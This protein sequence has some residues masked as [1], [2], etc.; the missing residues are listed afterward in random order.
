MAA[1]VIGN[2]AYPD[3][4]GLANPTNDAND[5][6]AKLKG[7]GFNAIIATD[8]SVK[9]MNKQL[10]AFV[11]LLKTYEV[12]LF[13]FAGHGI[14]IEGSNYLLAL[15]TEMD[16]ESDA[17]HTSLGLDR[18][19]EVMGESNA[20]TKIIVLDA[21]RKNPWKRA[22]HRGAAIRGL[23]SVYAP[24]GTI[25][26]FATSPGEVAYDGTGRNGTYTSALLQHIDAPDCSIE[27]MF[28]RV[29]NTVAAASAGKQ[30]SWEHTSLSGEFYFNISLGNLIAEYEAT[31]LSDSLF[32]LDKK[33]M[34]H[35]IIAGLK[36]G[37]WY[38]Q[39]DALDLLTAS[40]VNKMAKNSLFVIGRNI[41][42]AACGN[43]TTAVNLLKNFKM[44]T[45][46]YDEAKRK[47]VLDGMLF[48]IFFDSK[49]TVRKEIKSTYF[50]EV[51]EFQRHKEFKKSFDFIS[52]SLV[53]ASANLYTIPGKNH[54]LAATIV[55]KKGKDKN[56]DKTIITAVYI[57]GNNVLRSED[58]DWKAAEDAAHFGSVSTD[59]ILDR[60]SIEL[61]VPKQN[62]KITY[63]PALSEADNLRIPRGW[64]VRKQ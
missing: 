19:V 36:T 62:L 53:A 38:K 6:G 5:L 9:E 2:S 39:N 15:D 1:L 20:K 26:G 28:K 43:A 13:F 24:K 63:T 32:A 29:R 46:E 16:S 33:W 10:K 57:G 22:W 50:N 11:T 42:Q 21:C 60:L 54:D 34:S 61:V 3:G 18:V 56:K 17:K 7:Y 30:T 45:Q 35:R 40:A 51:F 52:E 48:E 37:N 4:Q 25:I 44:S 59:G 49:G 55:T 64:T 14:Q 31:A 23:A 41:Y 47:A 12:G 58:G 27:M 8:C